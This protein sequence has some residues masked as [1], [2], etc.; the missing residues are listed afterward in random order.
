[1]GSVISRIL[2][3]V[4]IA[5]LD[6]SGGNRFRGLVVIDIIVLFGICTLDGGI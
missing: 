1:M 2:K 5:G 6:V 3:L 4:F